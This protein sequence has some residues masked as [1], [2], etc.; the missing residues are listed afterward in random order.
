MPNKL[1]DTEY[2]VS[3]GKIKCD[4]ILAEQGAR[5]CDGD[6]TKRETDIDR[7][8]RFMAWKTKRGEEHDL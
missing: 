7:L 8:A 4:C 6:C 3:T 5:G 2:F 1:P